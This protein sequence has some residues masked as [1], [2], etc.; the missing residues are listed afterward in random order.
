MDFED[1]QSSKRYR[2]TEYKDGLSRKEKSEIHYPGM[3]LYFTVLSEVYE[4]YL[5]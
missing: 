3:L 4:E 1:V 2:E 5:E